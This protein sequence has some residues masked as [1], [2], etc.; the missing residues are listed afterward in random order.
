MLF[1]HLLFFALAFHFASAFWPFAE[2]SD[3]ENDN[4]QV[5]SDDSG[6][7][8]NC[9]DI[10]KCES[11]YNIKKAG[12][13]DEHMKHCRKTCSGCKGPDSDRYGA[14][15]CLSYRKQGYC[16]YSS[17]KYFKCQKTCS[18]CEVDGNWGEWS[19]WST[20]TKTCKEGKQSRTR[21]CNSPA[22]QYGGIGCAGKREEIRVCNDNVQCPVDGNWGEWSEWSTCTKTCREG[23]QSRTRECNS[24]SP[25]YGGKACDGKPKES[26]ICNKKVPCPVDGNWAEWSSWSTCSKTCKEGKQSRTRECK[27]PVPQYGGKL[28]DGKPNEIRICNKDVPCPVDGNWGEWSEWSTCTK[29][30][31]EGKQSRT[32]ECN[33]PS[34]LYG[35]KACD[36]KPKESRICNKKVPCPVD[37][38]WAE[39]SSW[40]TC[41][42]TCREGKQSRTR[43]C[44]SPA[45]QY[46][47]K[48]C[49]GKPNE[50][51]ICNK[52]V[53]CPVDGN[54]GKWSEWS[55][56]TKTCKE[57]K[58]SRSRECNS[59]TPQYGGKKCDG[60]STDSQVCNQNVPCPVD[61][62]WGEWSEWSTCTKTC[63][64]GKQSRTRECN[65]PAP[66]YGGKICEGK[67]TESQVCNRDVPCPV[68]GNWGEWS[69]WSTCTKTCTQ[70]KQSRTRECNLPAP[71]YGGKK[72]DG[73]SS[74]TQDCN[75]KV[76]CP[77]DGNWGQWSE[78]S[79]CSK[80][81]KE[82]KQSRTRECNSPAAQFGGKKCEGNSKETDTCNENVPCPVDGMWG[83]WTTWTA[84]S[85]TCGYG[86][87]ER[88][89]VCDNPKPAYNGASCVG[90]GY[91]KR[92][93]HAYYPC[94]INGNWTSWGAWTRCTKTCGLSYRK[95]S[96]S[97]TNP[98][99][100]YNGSG[101]DGKNDQVERCKTP[102]K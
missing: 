95:R 40:S 64:E 51:R 45:P 66:Q 79:T 22:P 44:K 38:N 21:K 60:Q 49:D 24:P 77:V 93:C 91:Q 92:R 14:E 34:P 100:Q 9:L 19:E 62:N 102:C 29:T 8:N 96:R 7:F 73:K 32:R 35:G 89:R 41:S 16:G 42:K 46:G 6:Y 61:G 20:C 27:S 56:C 47:G 39:W 4:N 1:Y 2:S 48:L 88:K 28:C 36:G 63:K 71:Q 25:L 59:P 54:W 97:C 98:P 26:R 23:K 65:S 70:G 31:R 83:S 11:C 17:F 94:P 99:P 57:G 10:Y 33:S 67:S 86:I 78:W 50:I 15:K 5:S 82:G 72:C 68:D 81:C 30:C 18:S 101:C 12:K 80:T 43:E 84:C 13:C 52:D 90:I 3:E 87:R 55:T 75:E 37:G 74:Q 85:K 53:P 76:P 58:Q 69:E